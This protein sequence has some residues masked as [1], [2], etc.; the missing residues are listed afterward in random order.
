M[1]PSTQTEGGKSLWHIREMMDELRDYEGSTLVVKIGG[2]SIAEDAGFLESV[3]DQMEFLQS[4]RV[5]LVLVHGGGPQIDVA[6]KKA[7]IPTM[8]AADGRRI[9]DPASMEVISRVMGEISAEVSSALVKHGCKTYSAA[10]AGQ[11]FVKAKSLS[12]HGGE[13]TGVPVA[14]DVAAILPI[15]DSGKAIVMN[16]VGRD[17]NLLDYNV[18][19]DD[20]A[21][22]LAIALKSKRLIMVTNVAGVYDAEKRPISLLTPAITRK[23]IADGVISGGMIPKVESAIK[24]ISCGVGGVAIINGHYDCSILGELLTKSG[25]GTLITGD[26]AN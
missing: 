7:G 12:E 20:C 26:E 10:A 5:R 22:A 1:I 25:F 19:A 6:L 2:N 9:T 15:L 24:A 16:S 21:M 11:C 8:K 18:N 3:A 4:R 14:V 13:R 23:L 17:E